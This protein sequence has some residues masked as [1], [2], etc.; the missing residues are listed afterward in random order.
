ML[1]DYLKT[2]LSIN[3]KMEINGRHSKKVVESK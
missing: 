1:E 2:K 3:F